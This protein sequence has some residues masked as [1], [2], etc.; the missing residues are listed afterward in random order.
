MSPVRGHLFSRKKFFDHFNAVRVHGNARFAYRHEICFS[1]YSVRQNDN[2][3]VEIRGVQGRF[4]TDEDFGVFHNELTIFFRNLVGVKVQN[5]AFVRI[6][7]AFFVEFVK[8]KRER[9]A[10]IFVFNTF[11]KV[12]Y[13]VLCK[14]NFAFMAIFPVFKYEFLCFERL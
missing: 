9:F 2:V 7:I 8:F 1:A 10:D 11:Y 12:V 4:D 6:F 13:N 3:G 14:G 5:K